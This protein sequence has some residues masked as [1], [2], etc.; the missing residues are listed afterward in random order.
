MDDRQIFSMAM[1]ARSKV[2]AHARISSGSLVRICAGPC[3]AA[4][5]TTR[6]PTASARFW[7]GN[8]ALPSIVPARLLESRL[9]VLAHATHAVTALPPLR[10]GGAIPRASGTVESVR[11]WL[12]AWTVFGSGFSRSR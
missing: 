9:N 7:E 5:T 11:Y 8:E 2:E 1:S 12:N 6:E 4:A 10:T 3:S